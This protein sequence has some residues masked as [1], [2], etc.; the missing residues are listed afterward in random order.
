MQCLDMTRIMWILI[1]IIGI[2]TLS[3]IVRKL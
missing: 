3:G 2:N 1:L